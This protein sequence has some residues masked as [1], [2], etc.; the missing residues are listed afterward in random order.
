MGESRGYIKTFKEGDIINGFIFIKEAG[1]KISPK[2]G[3]ARIVLVICPYC[4][5]ENLSHLYQ[6]KNGSNVSCGCESRKNAAKRKKTHG[7]SK[8]PLYGIWRGIR[9]RCHNPNVSCFH[10]YGG[11]GI[12]ICKEWDNDFKVFY[13]FAI[14]NGWKK[15]L[16]IDRK[17]NDGNYTPS[18]CRFVTST[19]NNRN[20][21]SNVLNPN[22]VRN[23]RKIISEKPELSN[24]DIG[25]L[26]NV[27]RSTVYS[28]KIRKTWKEV[29]I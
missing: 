22:K 23:I 2:G 7:L 21:S 8:H 4:K 1:K 20:T 10:R 25:E 14:N 17:D 18:N 24:A 19:I 29:Y 9:N 27:S 12:T 13:D 11:R 28:V 6:I 3:M 5:K 26:F 15:G 16:N